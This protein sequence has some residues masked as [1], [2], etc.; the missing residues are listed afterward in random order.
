MNRSQIGPQLTPKTT[1]EGGLFTQSFVTDYFANDDHWF[2]E[3]VTENS[4]HAWVPTTPIRLVHCEGDDVIPYAIS[5]LTEGTMNALGD[6]NVSIVPVETTLGLTV[7]V[8]HAPCGSLAYKV[9]TGIF[10]QARKATKGY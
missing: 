4:L 9:T 2:K 7:Q 3:A 1:G 6:V 8:K 5:Q 10:A